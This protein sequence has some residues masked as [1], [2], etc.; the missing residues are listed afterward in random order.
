MD[1][2]MERLCEVARVRN[3]VECILGSSIHN[4]QLDDF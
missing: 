1:K 2:N 3:F 4:I